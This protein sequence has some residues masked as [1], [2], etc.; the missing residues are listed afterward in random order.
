MPFD[1]ERDLQPVSLIWEMPNVAVAAAAK[2][3]ART[4]AEFVAWAKARPNGVT[5]GSP[6]VGTSPH[7]SAEL[8]CRRTGTACTHVPFRGAAQT[9]PALLSGDVDFALDNLASYVPAI[10]QGQLRAFAVTSAERWPQ[11]PDVPTMAE[12]GVPDFVVTSWAAW[13]VPQ[14]T[15]RGIVDRLAAALGQLAA[16]QELQQRSIAAG[17]RLVS[18]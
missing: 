18:S 4:L 12:A 10:Q 6:G 16:D 9:L 7:L 11:L 14:G 5:F 3:P 2:V 13:V 8:L 1:P 17:A 15:P